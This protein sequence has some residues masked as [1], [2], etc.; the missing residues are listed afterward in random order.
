[1]QFR[2]GLM[3]LAAAGCAGGVPTEL[4]V[5][6]RPMGVDAAPPGDVARR[7]DVTVDTSR[8]ND[9]S[10]AADTAVAIDHRPTPDAGPDRTPIG[11]DAGGGTLVFQ[12]DFSAPSRKWLC[13]QGDWVMTAGTMDGREIA[14]QNHDASCLNRGLLPLTRA[15]L[16]VAFRFEG[17]SVKLGFH[18]WGEPQ[19]HHLIHIDIR[20]TGQVTVVTQEGWGG[21]APIPSRQRTVGSRKIALTPT[22]WNKARVIVYDDQVRLWINDAFVLEAKVDIMPVA[23]PTPRNGIG[24]GSSGVGML[25]QFDDVRIWSLP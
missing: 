8:P 11:A 17:D 12:D 13:T 2:S 9:A 10:V 21:G 23:L 15:M 20:S 22:T 14:S 16:E 7:P 5:D 18:Y 3:V 24:L 1:M 4:I 19:H 6:D 25:G